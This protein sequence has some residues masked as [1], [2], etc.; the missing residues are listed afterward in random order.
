MF[1]INVA[2]SS[3]VIYPNDTTG[4]TLTFNI[5]YLFPENRMFYILLDPGKRMHT[6]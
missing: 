1:S 4:R 6:R 5:S 3:A 2:T